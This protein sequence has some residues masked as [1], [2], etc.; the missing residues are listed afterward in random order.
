MTNDADESL[1]FR[2][3]HARIDA[4]FEADHVLAAGML[5][6][7]VGDALGVPYEFTP[8]DRLPPPSQIEMQPP[9][10]FNRAHPG[11]RPGTWSDDGAHALCLLESLLECGGL[12]LDDLGRRLVRWLH[13]GHMAVGGMVFDVGMQTATAINRLR[14]GVPAERAGPAGEGD[15]GNGS[16]MRV[17]PLA[18][19]HRGG[20]AELVGLAARQSLVT[21]GHPRSQVCCAMYCLWVR[22][23]VREV[24]GAWSRAE[25]V[26]RKVAP[27][28][29]LPADEIDFVLNQLNRQMA[30]GSGY[31]LDALWSARIAVESSGQYDEVVRRAI[32]F[33]YDTDTTAAIAGGVAAVAP[34]AVVPARWKT[35]LSS[36]AP[37]LATI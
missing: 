37:R 14:M 21:H 7:L 35:A 36:L 5:G 1:P 6:L 33:G 17:L 13:G 16:L 23:T 8:P 10:G 29:R 4:A 3:G 18:L 22:E 24:D 32:C 15:N 31:V 28:A 20:D 25:D 19:W 26:M 12:D 34:R 27:I 2:I 9:P 30:R 11:V